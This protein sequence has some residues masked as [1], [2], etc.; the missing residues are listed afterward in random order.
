MTSFLLKFSSKKYDL[1]STK[2]ENMISILPR[3]NDDLLL[4]WN[5]AGT[6]V[7]LISM[8]SWAS[9]LEKSAPDL[10]KKFTEWRRFSANRHRRGVV[11]SSRQ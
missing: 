10:E 3:S 6:M 5:A 11:I 9:Y 1:G 4:P 8:F 7:F 2:L